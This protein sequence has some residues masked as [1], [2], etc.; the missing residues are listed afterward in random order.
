MGALP[1]SAVY[2]EGVTFSSFSSTLGPPAPLL[3]RRFPRGQRKSILRRFG[4]RLAL[5][6]SSAVLPREVKMLVIATAAALLVLSTT[7]QAARK[8][9][10]GGRDSYEPYEHR[11]YGIDPYESHYAEEYYREPHHDSYGGDAYSEGPSY[12]YEPT[13]YMKSTYRHKYAK[14]SAREGQQS[15]LLTA[16][17]AQEFPSC[18]GKCHRWG[19]GETVPDPTA[20]PPVTG[21]PGSFVPC[22][23][24]SPAAGGRHYCYV[25]ELCKDARRSILDNTKLW[26]T[27]ACC[28]DIPAPCPGPDFFGVRGP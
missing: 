7:A 11:V 17:E 22:S 16:R 24:T 27:E 15:S 1:L 3:V 21:D 14:R 18:I 10:Y 4:Q 8:Y 20:T 9:N 19:P 13:K 2:H 12:T 28:G 26:S 25:S 5:L 6:F 23:D